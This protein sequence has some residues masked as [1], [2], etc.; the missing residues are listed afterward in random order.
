MPHMM[1]FKP[2]RDV[3][4]VFR[5]NFTKIV[6]H[7]IFYASPR[8]ALSTAMSR[9]VQ[10][11]GA[12]GEPGVLVVPLL[13]GLQVPVRHAGEEV[14]VEV[15]VEVQV[16]VQVALRVEVQVEVQVEFEVEVEVEVQVEVQVEVVGLA[17][18]HED[19]LDL[20][21]LAVPGVRQ[22]HPGVRVRRQ[23]HL[24][25]VLVSVQIFIFKF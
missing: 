20:D 8:L 3:I 15:R 24:G 19:G 12:P 25:F 5:A 21:A 1:A 23:E 4:V 11:A 14:Q 16:E 22:D 13:C 6:P 17:P 2:H 18:E 7:K 10:G 9:E